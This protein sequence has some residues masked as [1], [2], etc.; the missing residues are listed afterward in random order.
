MITKQDVYKQVASC[1]IFGMIFG[2]AVALLIVHSPTALISS[3]AIAAV[4]GVTIMI[5]V[6]FLP[7]RKSN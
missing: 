7:E 3:N 4:W 2:T 6:S 1:I 5:V